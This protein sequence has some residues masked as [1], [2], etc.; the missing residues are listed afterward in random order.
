MSYGLEMC[1]SFAA[2]TEVGVERNSMS[3]ER[4]ELTSRVE[5]HFHNIGPFIIRPVIFAHLR[6][7]VLPN[8][9]G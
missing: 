6:V 5:F 9:T 8:N 4:S 2:G 3:P 1:S 7:H